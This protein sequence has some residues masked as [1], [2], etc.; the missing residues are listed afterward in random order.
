MSALSRTLRRPLTIS[1]ERLTV[2]AGF[3]AAG[4]AIAMGV[5]VGAGYGAFAFA[6]LVFAAAVCVGVI[7]WR[8]SVIGL[9]AYMP[10][11]GIPILALHPHA[12]PGVLAK[13]LLWVI[14]AYI[15]FFGTYIA[16]RQQ[17]SFSG[18]PIIAM[19]L[20]GMIVGIQALNPSVPEPLVAMIGIKVWL[21]YMPLLFLGYHLIRNE[22]DLRFLL[23]LMCTLAIVPAGIG[24]VEQL[25]IVAGNQDTVYSLYGDAASRATQNFAEVDIGGAT[26]RRVPSTFSFVAQYYAFTACMV[27]VA[28]GWWRG[29]RVRRHRAFR[30]AVWAMMMLAAF[31]SGARGAFAFIPILVVLILLLDHR[32]RRLRAP[33][34]M[35]TKR[36]AIGGA[37][38]V[39][40]GAVTVFGTSAGSLISGLFELAGTQFNKLF[41]G[42]IRYAFDTTFLGL[43]TGIDTNASRYAGED[44][45]AGLVAVTGAY[46]QESWWVKTV[47]ELGVVGFILMV[48]LYGGLVARAV[49]GHLHVHDPSLRATSAGI[50]ALLIWTLL[51]GFKGQYIDLDPLNVYFWLFAGMLMKIFVLDRAFQRRDE[52]PAA[53]PSPNGEPAGPSARRIAPAS[54]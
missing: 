32:P 47:L 45:A 18:A 50:T 19:V 52:A 17:I 28:Y 12:Q 21:L 22:K 14:P 7:N 54:R 38:A 41:I 39:G 27:A 33:V 37:V 4:F 16:R 10:F 20:F 26:L 8:W 51:Y 53:A 9:L 42:G 13:D 46:W 15:G 34:Q 48:F 30:G 3:G 36:W 5:A 25:L 23:G 2:V 29:T 31:L 44:P 35:G 1:P 11:S 49:Q 43:G 40:L 24:I 6:G